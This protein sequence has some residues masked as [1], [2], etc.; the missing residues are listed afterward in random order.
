MIQDITPTSA[1]NYLNA[2]LEIDRD[3]IEKLVK[4]RVP[5]NQNLALHPTAQVAGLDEGDG[6]EVGFLGILNGLFGVFDEGPYTGWGP[7]AAYY[8][9]DKIVRFDVITQTS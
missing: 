5:C 3:A 1:A 4:Q 9:D 6:Y 7:V 2:L 8:E